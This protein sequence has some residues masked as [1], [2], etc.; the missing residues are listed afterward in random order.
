MDNRVTEAEERL[1]KLEHKVA[2]NETKSD[3][4]MDHLE[5]KMDAT[6][7]RLGSE[8]E[9]LRRDVELLMAARE[10]KTVAVGAA[11]QG[12]SKKEINAV[13]KS[14]AVRKR[15]KSPVPPMIPSD[16]YQP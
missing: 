2:E 13:E 11:Q 1:D 10:G 12:L 5:K 6:E 16:E 3:A 14:P 9:G 8:I 15:G 7:R 4:R